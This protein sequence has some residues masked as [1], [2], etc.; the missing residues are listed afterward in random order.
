MQT[1]RTRSSWLLTRDGRVY[2]GV[3]LITPTALA[4]GVRDRLSNQTD[5]KLYL[6]ADARTEYANVAS[7]LDAVRAA[8]VEAVFL[9]TSQPGPRRP[10]VLVPPSGLEVESVRGGSGQAAAECGCSARD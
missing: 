1:G 8:G 9:L 6:K 7:V 5:K 10:G 2:L 3:D 4:K